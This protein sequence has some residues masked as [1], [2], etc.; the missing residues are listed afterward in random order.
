MRIPELDT[1][2]YGMSYHR[3][4]IRE[5]LYDS[6][7]PEEEDGFH[8]LLAHGGDGEHIPI[9]ARRLA[10]QDSVIWPWDISISLMLFSGEKPFMRGRWSPSTGTIRESTATWRDPGTGGNSG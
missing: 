10:R 9:D 4:M 5:N 2:V 8:V 3:Q 7:T 6:W 1:F